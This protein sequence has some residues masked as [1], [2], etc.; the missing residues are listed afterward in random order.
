MSAE[1]SVSVSISGLR[2]SFGDR[3]VLD[4]VSLEI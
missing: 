2:K 1:T 3:I 4:G